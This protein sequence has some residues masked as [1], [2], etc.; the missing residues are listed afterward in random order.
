MARTIETVYQ[1]MID[2]KAKYSSLVSLDS[3]STVAIW[4][5]IFYIMAVVIAS[6][7]QLQDVFYTNVKLE[8]AKL[9]TGVNAW[10]A[11]TLL[12]YQEG[13]NVSYNKET[14]RVE[15]LVEDT[16]AQI[17]RV[18]T[19]ENEGVNIV[20][21]TAKDDGAGGL[22]KLTSIEIDSVRQYIDEFKFAGPQIVLVSSDPDVLRL[23][24][25]VKLDKTIINNL[26]QSIKDI[27]VYPIEDAI[28]NFLMTFQN[29]NYNSTIEIIDL[30]D[31]IQAVDGVKNVKITL[32]QARDY[33]TVLFTDILAEELET[34][35]SYSGWFAVDP[36]YTLNDHITYL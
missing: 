26:G 35:K 32:A 24:M 28:N 4:K 11:Q 10:Y 17:L 2:E 6:F 16:T 13:Y 36:T 21:K 22:E 7:E 25:N 8:A 9:P 12:K 14:G 33:T 30:V 34:Y 27:T 31:A 5:T 20:L 18:A 23:A 1:S 15:Y 19:C 29:I 3:T